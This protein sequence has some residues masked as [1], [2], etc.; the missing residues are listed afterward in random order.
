LEENPDLA[1]ETRAQI[2]QKIDELSKESEEIEQSSAADLSS[3]DVSHIKSGLS[4][5]GS[6][7]EI[8]DSAKAF[9]ELGLF[10]EALS[11][12][13]KLFGTD[14]PLENFYADFLD[15]LFGLFTPSQ[16]AGEI[17]KIASEADVDDRTKAA[18]KYELGQAL[19]Q[20]DYKELAVECYKSVQNIDPVY[21]RIKEK[22]EAVEPGRRFESRYDYLLRNEIVTTDQLQKALALSKKTRK[23][24]EHVLMEQFKVSKDQIGKSLSAYYNCPFKAY[25]PNMEVPYELL[26]NLK[27]PFLL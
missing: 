11:E 10:K 9:K 7:D 3:E 26:T 2:Q 23:S 4:I 1:E 19:E 12:Y 14:Q 25:N 5:G 17:D 27:K 8:S 18:M 22:I 21:P 6:A 16:V 24:V 15:C 13:K 20:R